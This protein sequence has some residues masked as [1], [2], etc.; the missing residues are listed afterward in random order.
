MLDR[1]VMA[2][3]DESVKRRK[4]NA[5]DFLENPRHFFLG[6]IPSI[7]SLFFRES[8]PKTVVIVSTQRETNFL[9]RVADLD[10]HQ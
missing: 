4:T 3:D 5:A 6:A 8:L 10:T 2:S 7:F 1:L 9:R